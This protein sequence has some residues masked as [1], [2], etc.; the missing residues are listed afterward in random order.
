MK[1]LPSRA[2]LPHGLRFDVSSVHVDKYYEGTFGGL[3]KK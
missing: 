2:H 3:K 1:M